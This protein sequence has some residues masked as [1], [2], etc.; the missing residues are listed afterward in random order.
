MKR[1]AL[2]VGS[3]IKRSNMKI[4][5]IMMNPAILAAESVE[6]NVMDGYRNHVFAK[7]IMILMDGRN[8]RVATNFGKKD[9]LTNN[10]ASVGTWEID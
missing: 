9:I 8:V 6:K 5:G 10:A 1:I 7:L 4:S 2:F 3:K